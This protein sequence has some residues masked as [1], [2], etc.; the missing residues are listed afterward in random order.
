MHGEW[1]RVAATSSKYV[2]LT[3]FARIAER[4]TGRSP[5]RPTGVAHSKITL[6]AY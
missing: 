6:Y 2:Y 5:V 4:Y 1:Q 3:R